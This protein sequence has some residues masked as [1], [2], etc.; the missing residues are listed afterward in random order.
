MLK[1]LSVEEVKDIH[2]LLVNKFGGLHGVCSPELLD[3]GV[4]RMR[5]SF[6][7][8]DLYPTIFDKA[9]ALFQS[10]CKNHPFL[11]SNKRTSFVAAVTFL[12][13]NG[14]ETKFL[15]DEAEKF[16]LKV[17]TNKLEIKEI[18]NFFKKHSK[19]LKM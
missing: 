17:A 9:A 10:L 19:K 6:G 8:E 18:A 7:G 1:F 15:K 14:Y 12:E 13:I 3:S 4:A 2:D 5:A 16:V 11:D